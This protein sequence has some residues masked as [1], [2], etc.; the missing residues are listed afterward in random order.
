MNAGL[1]AVAGGWCGR[2]IARPCPKTAADGCYVCEDFQSAP[3][4][5]PIHHDTLART[6][7]LQ[8]TAE[9]AGRA[10]TAELNA[11]IAVGVE[12]LIARLSADEND[13]LRP[14]AAPDTAH[15]DHKEPTEDISDA[16]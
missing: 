3:Q 14:K 9:A 1:H 5:L 10:R 8:A 2:H 6:R 16:G 11:R 12:H 13:E 15:L 7:E 4:F